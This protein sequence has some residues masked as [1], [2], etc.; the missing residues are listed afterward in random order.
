[1]SEFVQMGLFFVLCFPLNGMLG[2]VADPACDAE[3][4]G[5]LDSFD[6]EKDAWTS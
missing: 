5:L 1:M 4:R 3:G 6:A 2:G